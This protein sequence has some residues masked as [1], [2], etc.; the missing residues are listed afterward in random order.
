MGQI[1]SWNPWA[2]FRRKPPTEQQLLQHDL[3]VLEKKLAKLEQER[4]QLSIDISYTEHKLAF[5][6][7]GQDL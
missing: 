2:V 4:L 5:F 7:K 1:K 3:S 6:D